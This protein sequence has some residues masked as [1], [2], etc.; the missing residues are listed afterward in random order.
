MRGSFFTFRVANSG[1]HTARANLSVTSHNVANMG[2]P[3]F[4]RQATVQ[5]AL[6][7]INLRNNRG[8]FGTGS[9]VHNVIQMRCQFVDRRFWH[10]QGVL[11]EHVAKVPNLTM[12]EAVFNEISDGGTGALVSFNDFFSRLQ[13]L[14]ATP[15]D[16]TFRL[17]VLRAGE[18]L[19]HMINSNAAQ[20]QQQQR[21]VNGEVRA[22]VTE[23]NNL[24]QQ[25]TILNRQIR[26]FEFDGSHANDLRDQRAL[27]IDRLSELVNVQ[28]HERD[29]SHHTGIENDMR[30]SILING[31]DFVHH[32]FVQRL[33][34]VPRGP[35]E[36]RNEMDVLGLYD[37]RFQNGSPFNIYSRHLRGTLRGLIDVRDGN[38]GNTWEWAG[39]G[40]ALIQDRLDILNHRRNNNFAQLRER[41]DFIVR[42]SDTFEYLNPANPDNLPDRLA[43]LEAILALPDTDPNWLDPDDEADALEITRLQDEVEYLT[44]RIRSIEGQLEQVTI[45]A[46]DVVAAMHSAYLD[47]RNM[48]GRVLDR[49]EELDAEIARFHAAGLTAQVNALVDERLTYIT[50]LGITPPGA[51]PAPAATRPI[52]P[53]VPPAGSLRDQSRLLA[54]ARDGLQDELDGL[55]APVSPWDVFEVL[56]EHAFD[57]AFDPEVDDPEDALTGFLRNS[58]DII[59]DI[60]TIALGLAPPT[61]ANNYG[62]ATNGST[63]MFR[64]IPFYQ[65]RLNEMVRVF[66]RAINEGYD[67]EGRPIVGAH[68]H[69]NGYGLDGRT[70]RDFFTWTDSQGNLVDGIN[71]NLRYLTALN[72]NIN[73][74]LLRYPYRLGA[75]L[76]PNQGES[77]NDVIRGFLDVWNSRSL[78]REGRLEDFIIATTGFLSIDIQQST[79]FRNNFHEMTQASINQ[80]AAISDVDMNEELMNMQR[81]NHLFQVNARMIATMND[82]YDTLINRLGVG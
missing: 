45:L 40:R 71:Y 25:I 6:P 37:I 59:G 20:L 41:F 70:G 27:L 11:G 19:A 55:A 58:W 43:G 65:N 28:V 50:F 66:A 29:M 61:A 54:V 78:F 21:D 81:F 12:I 13:E 30:L 35:N 57:P 38:G 56:R 48:E 18:T 22:V 75:A 74:E 52:M 79:R 17:N 73:Q 15:H 1:M 64:G 8:M 10:Q 47:S 33:E 23:I 62:M 77:E 5:S 34:L 42:N 16:P 39:I 26:Q 68:G 3:G 69:R 44:N 9:A 7:A 24:G 14:T 31:Y 63:T 80:R 36:K 76:A 82:V 60:H 72:I 2:I 4:S 46:D 32:D 67:V 49:I 51:P 53:A